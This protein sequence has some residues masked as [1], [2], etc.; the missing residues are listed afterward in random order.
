MIVGDNTIVAERLCDFF[1]NLSRKGLN[2]SKG[3]PKVF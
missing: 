2:A 1:K 3:W